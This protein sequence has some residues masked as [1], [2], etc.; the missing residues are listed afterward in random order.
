MQNEWQTMDYY[1]DWPDEI[2][3]LRTEVSILKAKL[4]QIAI[5]CTENMDRDKN[6]RIALDYV[7]QIANEPKD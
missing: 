1:G 6:H 4:E 3:R 7:R 5:V 2:V